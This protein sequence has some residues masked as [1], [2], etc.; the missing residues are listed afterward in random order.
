MR[1]LFLTMSGIGDVS[2][3]G[4]YTD[5]LREFRDRGDSV[6]VVT[7][8]ERRQERATALSVEDGI[9]VLRVRTGNLTKVGTAEKAVSTLLV[10]R[11]FIRAIAEYLSDVKFDLVIYSTPPVTFDRVVRYVKRRDGSRT[12]LLLKDIFPQ[13]AVDLGMIARGG[14]VWRYFRAREKRLYAL[15]D[16]IGCMSAA[17]VRYVLDHN[18][19]VPASKVEVCPNSI[20]PVPVRPRGECVDSLPRNAYG[21]PPDSMLMI[22]GGSLGAPQGLDFLLEALEECREREDLFFLI[23]GSGTE[24]RRIESRIESAGCSNARLVGSLPKADYDA[25]IAE[26]DVGLIFLDPRFTIPNFPSRLTAYMEAAVPVVAATDRCTDIREVLEESGCGIW[27]RNGDLDGFVAAVD[28]LSADTVL[29]QEMGRRGRTF[30][31]AHYTVASAYEIV[32]AHMAGE[33]AADCQEAVS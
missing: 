10:E 30:L 11:Q 5:L 24:Y 2:E 9:T 21:I 19:Q 26:C 13:N 33:W 28:R 29:R 17:N 16:H 1:L 3:R 32:T 20:S 14:L 22:L 31:E 27:L 8:C 7:P 18:P 6:Y 23:V 25:L 4:I 15:S 12:Y